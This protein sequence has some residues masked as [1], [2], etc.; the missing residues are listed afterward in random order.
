MVQIN[1]GTVA[2]PY[3]LQETVGL[4]ERE[5]ICTSSIDEKD[6]G[7]VWAQAANAKWMVV[8]VRDHGS[9]PPLIDA[10]YPVS[11]T[12]PAISHQRGQSYVV[13]FFSNIVCRPD[14]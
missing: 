7:E 11:G 6:G 8:R 4:S 13:Q 5:Q 10:H 12:N 14:I 9:P 2:E 1:Y 3:S